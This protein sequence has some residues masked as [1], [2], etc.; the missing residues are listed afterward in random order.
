MT[1]L[2]ATSRTGFLIKY[3]DENSASGALAELLRSSPGARKV[4]WRLARKPSVL[5]DLPADLVVDHLHLTD[6]G[7]EIDLL[8]HAG[9]FGVIVE[10]K[11]RDGKKPYQFDAYVSYWRRRHSTAPHLVWLLEKDQEVLG[12]DRFA[13]TTITWRMLKAALLTA[14]PSSTVAEARLMQGFCAAL[15]EAGIGQGIDDQ[16]RRPK[17]SVGY[18]RE[19]AAMILKGILGEVDGVEGAPI[20]INSLTPAIHA[21]RPEW[22]GRLDDP[23]VQRIWM[24][25]TP[26]DSAP[27]QKGPYYFRAQVLLY[28]GGFCNHRSRSLGLAPG[29]ASKLQSQGMVLR[30]NEPNTW[31]RGMDLQPGEG[32]HAG[33]RYIFAEESVSD[34]RK[35][36]EFDWRSDCAAIK[37][38]A[39]HLNRFVE[40]F[41]EVLKE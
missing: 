31:N 40:L 8:L 35:R 39:A 14:T 19:H 17:R 6:Q 10:C 37:A 34:A 1:H 13:A 25:F 28:Q 22:A 16:K 20:R 18:D 9:H 26:L 7:R 30:K 36:F 32:V 2:T 4:F 21:G 3:Q 5:T 33:I 12:D 15:T 38:G 41:D 29:W 24:Y 23:W 11:V 27:D